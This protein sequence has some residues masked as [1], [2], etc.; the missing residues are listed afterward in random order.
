MLLPLL[1]DT[2]LENHHNSGLIRHR[3]RYSTDIIGCVCTGV[4]IYIYIIHYF[5]SHYDTKG[6]ANYSQVKRV[7]GHWRLSMFM[8]AAE[9]QPYQSER[10]ICTRYISPVMAKIRLP[11]IIASNEQIYSNY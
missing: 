8:L 7:G 11:V 10:F 3:F 9:F 4:Y 1:Y 5:A 2:V 6:V